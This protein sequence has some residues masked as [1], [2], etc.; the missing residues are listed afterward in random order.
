MRDIH[1]LFL[2]PIVTKSIAKGFHQWSEGLMVEVYSE[3]F[4]KRIQTAIG[5]PTSSTHKRQRIKFNSIRDPRLDP[6]H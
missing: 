1:H 3:P 6:N 5:V 2:L 4:Y